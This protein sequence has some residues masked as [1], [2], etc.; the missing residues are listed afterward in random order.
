M[1][2]LL[3]ATANGNNIS[4]DDNVILPGTITP[5][6]EDGSRT[7]NPLIWTNWKVVDLGIMRLKKTIILFML[8]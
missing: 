7:Y 6:N 4:I 8:N 5:F 1:N 2:K 3:K